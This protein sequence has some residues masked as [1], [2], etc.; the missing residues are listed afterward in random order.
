MQTY[1][2]GGAVRDELLN[3]KVKDR[4]F[5]VVGATSKEMKELGFKRVGGTF[6]VFL[7]PETQEEYAL[8]RTERKVG[9]GHSGFKV[10]YDTDV[11][12]EE[13]L[14]RRDLTINAMARAT[15]DSYGVI[16]DPFGGQK[17]LKDGVL[18]HVSDAFKDDPLRVLRVARFAARY[19]FT[20][21]KETMKLMSKMAKSGELENLTAER[22]WQELTNAMTEEHPNRFFEV[23]RGCGAMNRV[24][25][26]ITVAA[27]INVTRVNGLE[28]RLM[29]LFGDAPYGAA[30][31]FNPSNR[32]VKL[33]ASYKM[34]KAT[35]L[36]W[37]FNTVGLFNAINAYKDP[38]VLVLS[39]DALRKV[40]GPASDHRLKF[41]MKAFAVSAEI[42]YND[43]SEKEKN[44]L[45]G[46]EIGKAIDRRRMK[47]IRE[48]R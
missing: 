25:P 42:G 41:I 11:T 44:T 7:H 1:V 27:T 14:S 39:V 15:D 45:K 34:V 23:L 26:M 13:D 4:D 3:R 12:L 5:V 37:D 47:A 2:V 33:I 46:K 17:D 30:S 10:K 48:M 21:A 19:D 8:A 32:I 20:V 43:L 31:R 24:F 36:D 38:E 29:V 22:V 28:E 40:L 9:R 18:R 16:I 6:P 35:F